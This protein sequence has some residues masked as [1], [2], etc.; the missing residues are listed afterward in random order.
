VRI[1]RIYEGTNGIQAMD[2][3]SR[4]L[5]DGGEAARALL[6]EVGETVERLEQVDPDL[7]ALMRPALGAMTEATGWMTAQSDLNDRFAGAVEYLRS[8]A[9]TRGGHYLARAALAD[10]GNTDR[11]ALFSVRRQVPAHRN[12][13]CWI[14]MRSSPKYAP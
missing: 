14:P 11:M 4:K 1:A 13:I 2:L 9:L 5:A 3:V 10:T 7:A 12:F 8:F 6:A